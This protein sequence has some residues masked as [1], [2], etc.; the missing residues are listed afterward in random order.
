MVPGSPRTTSRRTINEPTRLEGAAR[1]P[2]GACVAAGFVG[3]RA[4]C[5]SGRPSVRHSRGTIRWFA[6]KHYS[7]PGGGARQGIG[8][9]ESFRR[10]LT[11]RSALSPLLDFFDSPSARAT[12]AVRP[13]RQSTSRNNKAPPLEEMEPPAKF[14]FTWR[15]RQFENENASWLH[16]VT[17][18]LLVI[19]RVSVCIITAYATRRF[20]FHGISGLAGGTRERHLAPR[21]R[22]QWSPRP[23]RYREQ[24][25]QFW[26][27]AFAVP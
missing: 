1:M 20:L 18:W 19:S 2:S 8:G 26:H 21:P 10:D 7:S 17:V 9:D 12:F 5:T 23:K 24:L 22:Q 6:E 13:I 4:R 16:S 27:N 25:L 14:P 3:W 15:L 11:E